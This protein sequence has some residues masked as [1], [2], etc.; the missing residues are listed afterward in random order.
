MRIQITPD[1][2]KAKALQKMAVITLDR[3]QEIEIVKYPSNTLIDY[4]DI[5]HKLLEAISLT[6]GVKCK[7]DGAHY[8]LIDYVAM[9]QNLPEQT[10][11]FL[12]ELRE[13]RNRIS[14]EGFMVNKDYIQRN[15]EKILSIIEKLLSFL[16]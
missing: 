5:I 9:K 8:E 7:G 3:L 12:Q 1:P 10:R 14:Y 11:I 15:N 2:N 4:Y 6:S 16:K 13:Y